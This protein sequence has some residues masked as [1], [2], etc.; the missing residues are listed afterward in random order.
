MCA[1]EK[2]SRPLSVHD[3]VVVKL[4]EPTQF[5]VNGNIAFDARE[6][7]YTSTKELVDKIVYLIIKGLSHESLFKEGIKAS[8]LEPGKEWITGTLRFRF[9][10][11]FIPVESEITEKPA[12]NISDKTLENIYELVDKIS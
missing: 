5:W 7:L 1:L 8:V 12:T 9:V 6:S 11:E 4:A 10:F 3:N 2:P